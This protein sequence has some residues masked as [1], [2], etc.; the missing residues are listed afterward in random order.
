MTQQPSRARWTPAKQRLFLKILFDTGSVARAAQ[1][2]GMS[3]S[4]AHRLRRR[5]A[6]TPFDH[7]WNNVLAEHQRRLAD[8]FD[9]AAK[10]A[11]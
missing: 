5:L 11:R 4:S 2:A 3:R 10:A 6:D 7:A 1:A 8:P 9:R